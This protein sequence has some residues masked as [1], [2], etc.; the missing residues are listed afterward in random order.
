MNEMKSHQDAGR[1][2]WTL[3]LARH[4]SI[5]LPIFAPTNISLRIQCMIIKDS[6]VAC[7]SSLKLLEA[8][9]LTLYKVGLSI[10]RQYYVIV[11]LRFQSWAKEQVIRQPEAREAWETL[12]AQLVKVEREL[13]KEWS[14]EEL[15]E[16]QADS[17]AKK[18]TLF[19]VFHVVFAALAPGINPKTGEHAYIRE[20]HGELYEAWLHATASLRPA[21]ILLNFTDQLVATSAAHWRKGNA[22]NPGRKQFR[23]L[24]SWEKKL[25]GQGIAGDVQSLLTEARIAMLPFSVHS[26][27]PATLG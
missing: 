1:P 15:T 8:L 13:R 7:V 19:T 3:P 22:G 16:A 17:I 18:W 2:V 5:E 6:G 20:E 11:C 9:E 12:E 27:P 14:A 24:E 25:S 21:A 26:V 23:L 4:D 10:V